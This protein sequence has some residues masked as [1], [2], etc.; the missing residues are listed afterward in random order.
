MF[1]LRTAL[2]IGASLALATALSASAQD[3]KG[4]GRVNGDVSDE[5]GQP[6]AGAS[7]TLRLEKAPEQGPPAIQT[8]KKGKWQFLGLTGGAW[9]VHIEAEGY[10]PSEGVVS[11]S[12]FQPNPQVR[13]QLRKPQK[14]EAP[15]P[16]PKYAE[17]QAAIDQGDAFLRDKKGAEARA[18]YEKAL[19]LLEGNNRII[20]LRR[21]GVA[22]MSAG[23][24]AGAVATLKQVLTELP[25]DPDALR[26]IVD[27]LIILHREAEA[28][29]YMAKLP[30][31]QGLDPNTML[32]MGINLYNDNKL[33][34]AIA[35]FNDVIAARPDH[36][37][38]YYYRGL[39]LLAK[40]KM[41]DAK[42]DFKKVLELDPN[43]QFANDCRGFLKS[44]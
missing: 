9:A 43:G 8:D 31:G 27:R 18:E 2:R 4:R 10:I 7:V 15:K 6:L 17:A 24:D 26:L 25:D 34:D 28:Q 19:P 41:A 21:I 44:L 32:N 14:V 13:I 12:E 35:K 23:D 42:A 16:D 22:Q 20:V 11:V 29:E 38:G 36:A 1:P 33:D 37:D 5:S 3:W 39:A 30:Q 40:S